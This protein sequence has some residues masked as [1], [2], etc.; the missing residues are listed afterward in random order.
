MAAA[1]KLLANMVYQYK[2]YGLS[3]GVMVAGWDKK[4]CMG[5]TPYIVL[6]LYI[7]VIWGPMRQ[8]VDS[9]ILLHNI[10]GT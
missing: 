4:V 5:Y 8:V 10:N 6:C 9:L 1:S 3:M 7:I 2:G